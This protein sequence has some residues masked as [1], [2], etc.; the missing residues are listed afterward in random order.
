MKAPEQL[1]P[2]RRIEG[3]VQ[4]DFILFVDLVARMRQ[5]QGK[6]AVIRHEEQS[7]TLAVET[8]NVKDAWPFR[9]QAFIDGLSAMLIA[10]GHNVAPRLVEQ[11]IK[12]LLGMDHLLPYFNHIRGSNLCCK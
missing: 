12:R 5:E 10:R 2:V 11:D 6:I 3:L 8:A 1:L 7:L 9:G 4:G